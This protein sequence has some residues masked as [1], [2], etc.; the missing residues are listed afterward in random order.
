MRR[1]SRTAWCA[2]TPTY[3]HAAYKPSATSPVDAELILVDNARRFVRM[4]FTSSSAALRAAADRAAACGP[5]AS[6]GFALR[7]GGRGAAGRADQARPRGR[8]QSITSASACRGPDRRYVRRARDASVSWPGNGGSPSDT[9]G[10][11]ADNVPSILRTSPKSLPPMPPKARRTRLPHPMQDP[12]AP[13][14]RERSQVRNPPRPFTGYAG[15]S[16]YHRERL[17]LRSARSCELVGSFVGSDVARAPGP[18]HRSDSLGNRISCHTRSKSM[19]C[20]WMTCA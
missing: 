12:S 1:A 16:L 18:D 10:D 15:T 11:R 6:T 17:S 13:F 20:R 19:R 7:A 3:C 9:D 5:P 2:S 14:T 4:F 8:R